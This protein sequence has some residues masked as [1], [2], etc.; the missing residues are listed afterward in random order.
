MELVIAISFVLLFVTIYVMTFFVLVNVENRKTLFLYPKSKKKYSV[1]VVV[2]CYNE[3]KSV[4]LTVEHILNSNYPKDKLEVIIAND[5]SKD[6]T[7]K[8]ARELEKKYP[9]VRVLDKPNSGKAD[10]L[11]SAIR[12]ARGELVAVVDADSFPEKDSIKKMVGYFDDPKMGAVTSFVFVRNKN[13]NFLTYIQSIEYVVMGW[14]RKLLD[15]VDSVYV[16]N[17]PLSLY[18]KDFLKKVGGFDKKS[19]TEDIEVTWNLLFHKYKTAMCLDARV[20]T[21]APTKVKAWTR[22]RVRWGVG[23]IQALVKY[24]KTFFKEGIFGAFILP[25]VSFSIFLSIFIFFF[26]LYLFIKSLIVNA[27]R[28]GYS[29]AINSSIIKIGHFSFIPS[30][31]FFFM[32]IMFIFSMAY[33]LYI[34]YQTKYETKINLK[35]FFSIIFYTTAY[36]MLYP[37]VWIISFWRIF[38][39]D[40]RW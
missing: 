20:D 10:T 8:V 25:Y 12:M 30:V 32:A 17:G 2:P 13:H 15:Y 27:V 23:G 22:Q 40:Y 14:L 29:Y 7:L 34:I 9:N 24:K 4:K 11:N 37:F 6:D 16:T 36:L 39:R 1:S 33:Y 28:F 31:L 21:L 18:R 3:E 19:I 5:G 35:K 26:S 38:K